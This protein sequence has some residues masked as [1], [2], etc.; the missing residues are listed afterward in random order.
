MPYKR[1][2]FA[3]LIIFIIFTTATATYFIAKKTEP[4]TP[5]DLKNVSLKL[6]WLH[7]SQFAGNYSAQ[8]RGF[9]ADHGLNVKIE[10]FSFENPTID[11][12]ANA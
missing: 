3:L 2:F 8:L 11:A 9:Y 4:S 1:I 10:P 7:Q 12:V 6:K 5:K